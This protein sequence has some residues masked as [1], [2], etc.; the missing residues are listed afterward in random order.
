MIKSK[1]IDSFFKRKTCNE[2]EKMYLRQLNLRNF[3]RIQELRKWKT[4]L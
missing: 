1:Q 4:T 3:M 2:D